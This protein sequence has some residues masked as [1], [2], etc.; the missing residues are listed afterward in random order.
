MSEDTAHALLKEIQDADDEE[1]KEEDQFVDFNGEGEDLESDCAIN[2]ELF[3]EG[4]DWTK[5]H[6]KAA[7]YMLDKLDKTQHNE[8]L[9]ML[10]HGPPG[11]GKT[12]LIERLQKI[13]NI[14]IR[15]RA[16]SGVAAM[17]L[18]GT[19]IDHFL[20]RGR[21]K[22]KKSKVEIVEKMLGDA[23]L[24][25]VDEVSM[26]GCS[27]LIELD[28]TLQKLKKISAPFGGLDVIIVGDFVQLPPW[29]QTPLIQAM[30]S[31][32]LLHTPSTKLSMKTAALFSRFV[33]Y[34]FEEFNRSKSCTLLSSFLK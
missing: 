34:D 16:T 27:K 4:I 2:R 6:K 7:D 28:V 24:I 26:L 18:K 15:I 31:S 10:L 3:F 12:F 22:K 19:T 30:V 13:T 9:L 21:R 20:G 33:K 25:V 14:K 11:T 32:T 17:S 23:T 29:K 8:Q 1:T 5:D